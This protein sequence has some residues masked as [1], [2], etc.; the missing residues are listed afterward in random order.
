M[1]D[2]IKKITNEEEKVKAIYN[3]F[4]EDS[5]LSSKA[6]RVEF[7]T[8]VRAI[9]KVLKPGMKILDLGAGAGEYSIYFADKGYQVTSVELVEKHVEKIK[10]KKTAEMKLDIYQ[11]N[12]LDID[13]IEDDK[14]D[15]VLCFGPL[16]HLKKQSDKLKCLDE[17]KRA[18]KN[19]ASI[20]IAFISNDMVIT[21]ET[22]T[23]DIEYLNGDSCNSDNFKVSD[24]IFFVFHTVDQCRELLEQA[25]LK[26]ISEVASDGLSE[27]LADKINSMSDDIYQ[28]WLEYHYYCSEKP[29]F[30]GCSNHFLFSTKKREL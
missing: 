6:R 29:E 9:E 21:T 11:G 25:D 1:V 14:F 16:Y 28:K 18:S 27:L 3:Y 12:A 13:F 15:I 24:D 4:N 20:F 10:E 5:R 26:I 7:L 19:S 22:M 30:L 23:Y 8:N 2:E 17:V